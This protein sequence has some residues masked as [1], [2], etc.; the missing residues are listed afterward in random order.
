M[1][2][3]SS[4][5]CRQAGFSSSA[6]Q[7]S[8]LPTGPDREGKK[9]DPTH[10]TS[11]YPSL[12]AAEGYFLKSQTG[13]GLPKPCPVHAAMRPLVLALLLLLFSLQQLTLLLGG[14]LSKKRGLARRLVSH[15]GEGA[16]LQMTDRSVTSRQ[17]VHFNLC[18]QVNKES[19][20]IVP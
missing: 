1:Y 6:C 3:S 18:L 20:D 17:A 10:R 7:A 14:S 11:S 13:A 16:R 12:T 8:R 4:F 5:T 15:V 19:V 2:M 9:F